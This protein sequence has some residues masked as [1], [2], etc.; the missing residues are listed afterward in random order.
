MSLF[1]SNSPTA[2][3]RDTATERGWLVCAVRLFTNWWQ[4]DRVR[5]SPREGSLLRLRVPCII[6]I[7]GRYAQVIGR[8]TGQTAAGPYVCYECE[9]DGTP[10]DL[11]VEPIG[12]RGVP[13]L[14]WR[15]GRDERR[16]D[17]GDVEVFG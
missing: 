12:E 14:R 3:S 9:I 17:A 11:F 15:E 10:A 6:R 1:R 5:T 16:L 7:H 2:G 4:A 8:R 13:M